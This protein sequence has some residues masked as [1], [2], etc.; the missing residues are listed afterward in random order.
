MKPVI[1]ALGLLMLTAATARIQ[2]AEKEPD[3]HFNAQYIEACSC[4]LFC[5]CYM[6]AKPDKDFCKMDNAIRVKSGHY[7]NVK[8]DG[9]KIWMSGDLGANFAKGEA[10]SL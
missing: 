9:M 4:N 1:L 3:W 10:E 6:D 7:G 2:A 8:L 5:S